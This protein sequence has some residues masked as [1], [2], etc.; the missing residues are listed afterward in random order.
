MAQTSELHRIKVAPK[1]MGLNDFIAWT[2]G[3]L[4]AKDSTCREQLEGNCK[5]RRTVIIPKSQS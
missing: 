5:N 1:G 3:S 4:R 2:K